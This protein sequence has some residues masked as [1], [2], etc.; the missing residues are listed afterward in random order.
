MEAGWRDSPG[1]GNVDRPKPGK[2]LGPAESD[3]GT[4]SVK[5]E[6]RLADLGSSCSAFFEAAERAGEGV[7]LLQDTSGK[8]GVCVFS[9][10]AAA[11]ITGYSRHELGRLSWSELLHPSYR[12]GSLGRYRRRIRG[13]QFR[14]LS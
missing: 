11:Q 6:G 4:E 1:E 13:E 10:E 3:S 12:E 9:N 8:E 7:V 14:S 2:E 5:S